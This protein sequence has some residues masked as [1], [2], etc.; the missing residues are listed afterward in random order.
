[1]DGV[2]LHPGQKDKITFSQDSSEVKYQTDTKETPTIQVGIQTAGADYLFAFKVSGEATG[3]EVDLKLD[4]AKG[5]VSVFM[6]GKDAAAKFD[7]KIS[8]IDPKKAPEVYEH[9]GT[10]IAAADTLVF[11]YKEWKGAHQ[12]MDVGTD[13]GGH[14]SVDSTAPLPDQH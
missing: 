6:H 8:R 9:R 5:T 11:K 12:P 13:K 3:Q 1:M 2:Q 10:P 14:G 7:V 4:L